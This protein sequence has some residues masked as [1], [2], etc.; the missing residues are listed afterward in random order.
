MANE[1]I[2]RPSL[3]V[4]VGG[5][6]CKIAEAVHARVLKTGVGQGGRVGVLAFDT[7]EGDMRGRQQLEGRQRIQLSSHHTVDEILDRYPEVEERWFVRPRT[8]LPMKLRRRTLLEG[9]AQIRLLTRLALHEALE[10][11]QVSQKIGAALAALARYDNTSGY[12][13]EI[14]VLMAGSLAGATG[15]G[16]FMQLSL[17]IQDIAQQYNI[18]ASVRGLFLLPDIYV[19]SGQLPEQQIPNVLANGYASL[20]EL[21]AA[22][23]K[24]AMHERSL[25]FTFEFAPNRFLKDGDIPFV[26]LS[27]IDYEDMAGGNLGRSIDAYQKLAEHAAYTLLFTPIGSTVQ[28]VTVNDARDIIQAAARGTDNSIVGLG[29]GSIRYPHDDMVDYLGLKLADELLAGDWLRLDDSFKLRLR[30]FQEQRAAGNMTVIEPEQGA[31]YLEDM[32]QLALDDNHA[33]FRELWDE[34]VQDDRDDPDNVVTLY[35]NYLDALETHC[36]R[37]F[38]NDD[39]LQGI[40]KQPPIDVGQFASRSAIAEQVRKGENRLD[41]ALR[42]VDAALVTRPTDIFVNVLTGSDDSGEADWR[43]HH[44]QFHLIASGPHLVRSRAFLFGLRQ[45]LGKRLSEINAEGIRSQLFKAANSFDPSRSREPTERQSP[46][47]SAIARRI[48][49]RGAV[50]RFISSSSDKAFIEQYVQYHNGSM[51]TLRRF[52]EARVR[53]RIYEQLL[54]EVDEL[55]RVLNGLFR[56]IEDARASLERRAKDEE[57]RHENRGVNNDN[58]FF[59]YADARC[60]QES[61]EELREQIGGQRLE[62]DV[63]K[64]LASAVYA[65]ARRNRRAR[66]PEGLEDLRDLFWKNVVDDF[67]TSR[68]RD[69]FAPIHDFSVVEAMRREAAFKGQDFIRQLQQ[70]VDVVARQAEPLISLS[71]RDDGQEIRFWTL[72]SGL[73]RELETHVDVDALFNPSGQGTRP[74]EEEEFDKTE[75]L[76]MTLRVQLEFSHLAKLSPPIRADGS[77]APDR[78]GRYYMPYEDMVQG[79]IE[80]ATGDA[81]AVSFTP[82]VDRTWHIPGILPEIDKAVSRRLAADVNRAFIIALATRAMRFGESHGR[83]VTELDTAGL[84]RTGSIQIELCSSHDLFDSLRALELRPEAVRSSLR[85]WTNTSPPQYAGLQ[86][87]AGT[88]QGLGGNGE[89]SSVLAKGLNDEQLLAKILAISTIRVDGEARNR[90]VTELVSAHAQLMEDLSTITDR[91]LPDRARRDHIERKLAELGD[92]AMAALHKASSEEAIRLARGLHAKGIEHWREWS[93]SNGGLDGR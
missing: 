80:A 18:K 79:L 74:V 44:L 35:H 56:E 39:S 9:A 52:T 11:G 46:E 43:D 64:S 89:I 51:R 93:S 76:C 82:H 71:K 24:A 75:L 72:N 32:R 31:S 38:W 25:D 15:S 69:D 41:D 81:P 34:L 8:A 70:T 63:N 29:L 49:Q 3:L 84:V 10:S 14:N 28:S 33:F 57:T 12:S 62:A 30:R 20:K 90:R 65:K 58:V 88:F 13:G 68:T 53:Q 2:F 23:V 22:I 67:A 45:L 87:S 60:K 21:H 37:A 59:V 66:R 17:L 1:Q 40:V 48:A 73:R 92:N 47:I 4:G 54:L 61:W 85:L 16:S 77:A 19:R 50:G 36:I 86:E 78:G 42:A 27:L 6:G 91:Q 7:D 55:V 5:T 26:S 83:R